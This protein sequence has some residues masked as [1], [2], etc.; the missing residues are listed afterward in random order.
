M[1]AKG[2]ITKLVCRSLLR[3][4]TQ[5]CSETL[6]PISQPIFDRMQLLYYCT[7]MTD[8]SFRTTVG[9]HELFTDFSDYLDL[10]PSGL[11]VMLAD[12]HREL[13]IPMTNA[14]FIGLHALT[15]Q[16][17]G[18]RRKGPRSETLHG[19]VSDSTLQIYDSEANRLDLSQAY[20][21]RANVM[22]GLIVEMGNE[23]FSF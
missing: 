4:R 8:V 7:F 2:S 3:E 9:V 10:S 16:R 13:S 1:A 5:E 15:N 14:E 20:V 21:T 18:D 19:N 23:Q 6:I 17:L 12:E 11:F 22:H